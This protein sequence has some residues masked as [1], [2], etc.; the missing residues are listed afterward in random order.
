MRDCHFWY[1]LPVAVRTV[2]Y[3]RRPGHVVDA[4]FAGPPAAAACFRGPGA[5]FSA[6]AC[7]SAAAAS[8]C[9]VARLEASVSSDVSILLC[10]WMSVLTLD[11]R[12]ASFW[13]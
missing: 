7:A 11:R 3:G 12:R 8:A 6:S 13:T 4:C 2:W 5:F 1:T 10:C 9:S